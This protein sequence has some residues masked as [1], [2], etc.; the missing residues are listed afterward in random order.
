MKYVDEYRDRKLIAK[1]AGLIREACGRKAYTFMEVC[2]T[3]TMAIA[4]FG[5]RDLLPENVRLISGPGCPVCVTPVSYVDKAIAI[6]RMDG[7]TVATFGD[8]MRVPGSRSSLEKEKAGGASVEA[9]YSTDDALEM[10]RMRPDRQIVFLGVGFETTAPTVAASV[11]AAKREALGNYS[12]LSAHKTMPEAIEAL[13]V[14]R[15]VAVDGF[16]LPG[17]VSA[18]IGTRPYARI[19]GRYGKRCVIAGFE[20][21]DVMEAILMLVRQS[22]PKVE[23]QYRRVM[24]SSGNRMAMKDMALVFQKTDAVWRGIGRIADSGLRIRKGYARFDAE[25]RFRP[26]SG[27]GRE[28]KGCICG[29]VL[30]GLSA[31][32]DCRLYGRSCTPDHPV[33]A[34]MVSGEGTCA[35]Y[36]RYGNKTG[37]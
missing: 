28:P 11:I 35:A 10:A 3:H 22:R 6:A 5:L 20:P 19:A 18:V 31:P 33:G 8:M 30:K 7:V 14:G 9:V 16:I 4:R 26:R 15:D 34:C 37:L 29:D 17:H 13:L 27:S 36:Y 32:R 24:S 21:L 12:V 25:R 1:V 2:G 23:I